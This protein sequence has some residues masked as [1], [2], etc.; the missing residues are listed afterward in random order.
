[1]KNNSST[2]NSRNL[3][4]DFIRVVA[5]GGRQIRHFLSDAI[6]IALEHDVKVEAVFND[7][8]Y[9]I[10]PSKIIDFVVHANAVTPVD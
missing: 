5:P 4:I 7:K 6:S 9:K 2:L 10:D 1:M 3:F 8:I